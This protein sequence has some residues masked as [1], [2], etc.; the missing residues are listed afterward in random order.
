[1]TLCLDN[2][3]TALRPGVAWLLFCAFLCFRLL[4]LPAKTVSTRS[5]PPDAT[6][7]RA[8]I[9]AWF[10]PLGGHFALGTGSFAASAANCKGAL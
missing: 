8:C 10:R 4:A 1:V 5:H 7:R 6:V 9:S 3:T 2:A